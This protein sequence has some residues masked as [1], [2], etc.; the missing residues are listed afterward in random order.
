MFG[1][2]SGESASGRSPSRLM[3]ST[4]CARLTGGSMAVGVGDGLGSI[5]GLGVAVLVAEAVGKGG[6]GEAVRVGD[7]EGNPPQAP[8]R[9]PVE[10][11]RATR[12]N[13]TVACGLVA[14]TQACFSCL[15]PDARPSI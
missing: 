5:V 1:V 13:L 8:R 10:T 3:M 15:L 7:G 4:R 9:I 6:V 11:S 12:A 14:G 2:R